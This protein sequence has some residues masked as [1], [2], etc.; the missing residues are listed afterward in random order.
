MATT[1]DNWILKLRRAIADEHDRTTGQIIT[2]ATQNGTKFT[3]AVLADILNDSVREYVA[4]LYKMIGKERISVE[5]PELIRDESMSLTVDDS[6][7]AH[8]DLPTDFGYWLDGKLNSSNNATSYDFFLVGYPSWWRIRSHGNNEA[9]SFYGTFLRNQI[10][11]YRISAW[12]T[13]NYKLTYSYI[14]ND[15]ELTA[16]GVTDTSLNVRHTPMIIEL[17][18]ARS[19]KYK[20]ANV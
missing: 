11:I 19:A 10:H 16:G 5:L 15:P 1:F 3:A 12:T 2:L 4:T 9:S 17:A 6:F 20:T 18:I 13:L 8:G 14:K 7:T